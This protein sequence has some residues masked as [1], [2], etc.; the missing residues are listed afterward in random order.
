MAMLLGQSRISAKRI[1]EVLIYKRNVQTVPIV[2]SS[3]KPRTSSDSNAD[4]QKLNV[5]FKR[6]RDPLTF[7]WKASRTT[8]PSDTFYQCE[9]VFKKTERASHRALAYWTLQASVSQWSNPQILR[10]TMTLLSCLW[11]V[12]RQ[13]QSLQCTEFAQDVVWKLRL[14]LLLESLSPYG[15][16]DLIS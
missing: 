12:K 14:A 2:I 16:E 10:M 13:S 15:G 4:G 9:E 7:R 5:S 3:S 1:A 6:L 8:L 11:S